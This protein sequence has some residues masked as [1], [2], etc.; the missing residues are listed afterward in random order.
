MGI[1]WPQTG[2]TLNNAQLG[3]SDK[4]LALRE[5]VVC[6]V[7]WLNVLMGWVLRQLQVAQSCPLW[8]G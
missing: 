3:F 7:D 2:V 4:G 1:P 6:Y 5:L 8:S